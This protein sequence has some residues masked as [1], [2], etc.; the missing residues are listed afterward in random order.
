MAINFGD[1]FNSNDINI[2]N[3]KLEE[4]F[5]RTKDVA[6]T[7]GKKSAERL[8]I[9]RKKVEL[10]DSKAKLSKLYE[11]FGKMQYDALM[12]I[13]QDESELESVTVKISQ[14]K[15]KIDLLTVEIDEAKEQFNEAVSNATKKT[16]DAIHKEFD[17]INKNEV[18]VKPE[19]EAE[20][21]AE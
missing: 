17:R 20:Q 14:F 19:A 13:E 1:I 8:E 12:G 21:T 15:D 9:S 3:P 16:R 5:N 10:L 11:K 6:E 4:V 18:T 2:N 7:V